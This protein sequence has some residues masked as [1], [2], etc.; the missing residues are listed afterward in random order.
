MD[1]EVAGETG[2]LEFVKVVAVDVDVG[3]DGKVIVK[4]VSVVVGATEDVNG[5]LYL[6][7]CE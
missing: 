7:E 4:A 6:C 1:V 5:V 2:L 3:N